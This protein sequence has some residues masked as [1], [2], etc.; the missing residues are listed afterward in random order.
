MDEIIIDSLEELYLKIGMVQDVLRQKESERGG[1]LANLQKSMEKEVSKVE[2]MVCEENGWSVE[3]YEE[4]IRVKEEINDKEV[5]SRIDT[6][7][8]ILSQIL[9]G[10]KPKVAFKFHPI[11][12]KSLSISLYRQILISHL[13]ISYKTLHDLIDAGE[14]MDRKRYSDVMHSIMPEKEHRRYAILIG[15]EMKY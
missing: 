10:N 5:L 3:E 4:Q 11:F 13:Y 7:D 12:T 1:M 15:V 2:E 9:K 14:N 6:L 8:L